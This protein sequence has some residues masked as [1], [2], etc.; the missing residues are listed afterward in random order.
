MIKGKVKDAL[1]ITQ[2]LLALWILIALM[3][4]NYFW[5]FPP[6]ILFFANLLLIGGGS[7]VDKLF[8]IY[9]YGTFIALYAVTYYFWLHYFKVFYNQIP[10][11]LWLGVHP[12]IFILWVFWGWVGPVLIVHL[13]YV[14][15]F[16]KYVMND[17]NWKDFVKEAREKG[18][19]NNE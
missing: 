15:G 18:E 14:L 10:T 9:P 13:S 4:K 11:T 6:F 8:L 5:S 12:S 1:W 19:A 16:N 7:R 3:T 17:K 2:G